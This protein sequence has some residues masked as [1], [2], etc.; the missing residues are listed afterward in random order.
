MNSTWRFV[1]EVDDSALLI[2]SFTDDCLE[3]RRRTRGSVMR[4]LQV[5]PANLTQISCP[6]LL[7][8]YLLTTASHLRRLSVRGNASFESSEVGRLGIETSQQRTRRR[9]NYSCLVI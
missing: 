7:P 4:R 3:P 5:R 6:D 9:R 2:V 1:C 8:Q